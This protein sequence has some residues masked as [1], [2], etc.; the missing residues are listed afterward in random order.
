MKQIL[1]MQKNEANAQFFKFIKNNYKQWIND[2][3]SSPLLSH[4]LFKSKVAPFLSEQKTVFFIVIDN[5]RY[6]QWKVIEPLVLQYFRVEEEV[7]YS[8]ILP[9]ST[10]Y[11]RNAIFS[12]LTPLE[13]QEQ[14]KD[15]WLDDNEEGGKNNYEFELLKAQ[16]NRLKLR[17]IKTSYNKITNIENGRKLVQS[18]NNLMANDLNTIVYNFVDMLS[19][20]RTDMKVIKELTEGDNAYR[21]LTLSWFEHSPLLEMMKIIAE[22]KCKIVLTTDHGTIMVKKPSKVLGDKHISSNLRYK[23]GKNMK[24]NSKEVFEMELPR[25]FN[26]PTVNLSSKYIFAKE[27]Y[28]FAYPN[29]YNHYV[30]HYKETYQHGGVSLEEMIIPLVSLNSK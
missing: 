19:H 22:N 26:L 23:Q 2:P 1:E 11:S 27:D 3:D 25:E 9:T 4:N 14:H 15:F 12:G 10:Q 8:S 21:S 16:L 7:L 18:F 29:N 28:F 30:N 5:L 13:I 6:D 24:Y 17:H 20:S